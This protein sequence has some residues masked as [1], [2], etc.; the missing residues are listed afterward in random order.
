MPN[1]RYQYSA[2]KER[3]IKRLLED[4][5]YFATRSAGSHTPADVIAIK[6]TKC[7][8]ANHFIV[9]FIQIKTSINRKQ[10]KIDYE[11]V[12]APCGPINVEYWKLS[13]KTRKK[14]E[15]S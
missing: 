5:G 6:P 7:G 15:Q 9:R 12:D 8:H 2:N 13:H 11:V 3:E 1:S 14:G 10:D 4:E